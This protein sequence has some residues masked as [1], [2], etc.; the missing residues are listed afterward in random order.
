MNISI[1]D[2]MEWF[3]STCM[4]LSLIFAIPLINNNK[5]VKYMQHFYWYSIVASVLVLIKYMS[6]W[7]T[8]PSK[9]IVTLLY[10]YSILF[11]FI[12]LSLFILFAIPGKKSMKVSYTVFIS[13]ILL[14][15]YYLLISGNM[16]QN[17]ISY[18][19]AN[20]GLVFY[21]L[22]YYLNLFEQTPRC[23]LL[24]EP[25][26]WVITGIFFCMSTS[27]PINALHDYLRAENL[28]KLEQKKDLFS[29]AYFS[30]GSLHLFFIKAY[31]CSTNIKTT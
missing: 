4:I 25:S 17:S 28:V 11:H 8:I 31:L 18:A 24:Q 9:Y 16:R 15:L 19:I 21:C 23:I 13:V 3:Q 6:R 14:T 27:I 10:N 12:F 5:V 30:Y 22:M 7:F 1:H 20:L 2:I 29:I 26:F